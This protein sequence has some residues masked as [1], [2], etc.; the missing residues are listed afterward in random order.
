MELDIQD[1]TSERDESWEF[2][3]NELKI[4]LELLGYKE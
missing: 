4:E 3:I 1:I 2:R